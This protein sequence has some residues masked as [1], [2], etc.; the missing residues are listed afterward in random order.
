MTQ[1]NRCKAEIKWPEN[2]SP[3]NKPNNPDGT[4]HS[5]MKQGSAPT[6]GKY[7]S[8]KFS[9]AKATEIYNL[10]ESMLDSFKLKRGSKGIDGMDKEV[11]TPIEMALD[12]EAIFIESMFRTISGNFKE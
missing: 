6:G 8:A 2:Y 4:P 1:C 12:Q 11:I 3:G 5:C 10:A 7:V 9:V